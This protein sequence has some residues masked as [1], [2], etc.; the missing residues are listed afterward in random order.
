MSAR[1]MLVAA[2]LAAALLLA[3]SGPARPQDF[4]EET[5][6]D[7]DDEQDYEEFL[8]LIETALK[9]P[10]NLATASRGEILNLPWMSPWLAD[11]ILASRQRGELR[12]VDD[13][14]RIEGMTDRLLGILRPMVVVAPPEKHLPPLEG[15]VRL[16]TVASPPTDQFR[17]LKTYAMC[18]IGA[19]GL[20]AG[21]LVEKDRDESRLN[22]F[23]A[24]YVQQS[25]ARTRVIVGD[26]S[27][28]TG[29]GLV[30]SN[31]YG[32]SPLTVDPWRMSRGDFALKPMT[33]SEE[34]F[35]LEGAGA[36][37]EG[38]RLD[39]CGA[40]SRAKFDATVDDKGAVTSIDPQGYHRS[41]SEVA[42]RDALGETLVAA[43]A[44]LKLGAAQVT[45]T[46][47]GSD[48]DR[49][50]AVGRGRRRRSDVGLAGG[51]DVTARRGESVIFAEAAVADG[52]AGAG[53]SG[54]VLAGLAS[55]MPRTEVLVVGRCYGRDYLALHS[56]PF[57]FYSGLATGERGL[58]T[59]LR[60]KLWA[61]ASLDLGNDLHERPSPGGGAPEHSGS[62][63]FGDLKVKTG[64]FV[65]SVGGKLVRGEEPPEAIT[66]TTYAAR[67]VGAS[68]AG[69]GKAA[70]PTEETQRLRSRLD[71]EYRPVAGTRLRARYENLR[72]ERSES[73]DT[74]R[75]AADL[76]RLDAAI[77]RWRPMGVDL[78]FYVF[79]V[80]DYYARIYQYEAGM[81][82]YPSL[83]MLQSDGSRWYAVVSLGTA[84]LGKIAAKYGRTLYDNGE[85]ASQLLASYTLRF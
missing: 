21:Y 82:Y 22:D 19:G 38:S 31:P 1:W 70:D 61:A 45:L 72:A 66:D 25:W 59:G 71:I 67:A 37:H 74:V 30:L 56:R 49:D 40:V 27:V 53:R 58:Y 17:R 42:S 26:F 76:L 9:Q 2:G 20:K 23:Q 6:Q 80:G 7:V 69:R 14:G 29:H 44:R 55:E 54:A 73:G 41:R 35:M 24:F 84:G 60:L 77:D 33:S 52:A 5:L 48:F 39:V 12:T 79:S 83:E 15:T 10:V 62:E 8:N 57:G 46:L 63:T 34:N 18:N 13:L 16:R 32:T 78:G 85:E 64:D 51:L 4:Y 47:A 11:S 68:A 3:A 28:A 36:I 65:I 43:A 75:S 81:P 50:L